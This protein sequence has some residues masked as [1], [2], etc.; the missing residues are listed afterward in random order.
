MALLYT[1]FIIKRI[2]NFLIL[3]NEGLNI[4]KFYITLLLKG[5]HGR[6]KVFKIPFLIRFFIDS[7]R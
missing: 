3:R 6:Y 5:Y 1:I 4:I 7:H 2:K